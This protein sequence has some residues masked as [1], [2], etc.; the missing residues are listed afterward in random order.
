MPGMKQQAKEKLTLFLLRHSCFL[1]KNGTGNRPGFRRERMPR[2]I[3]FTAAGGSMIL[4]GASGRQ[5]IWRPTKT[6][7]VRTSVLWGTGWSTEN[8]SIIRCIRDMRR[9]IIMHTGCRG[10]C[11]AFFMRWFSAGR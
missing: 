11:C 1:M 9:I 7:A 6:C 2:R 8:G 3:I 5:G 4:P 10:H